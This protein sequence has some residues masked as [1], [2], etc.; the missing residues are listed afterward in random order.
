[1]FSQYIDYRDFLITT[2]EA[3]PFSDTTNIDIFLVILKAPVIL[4]ELKNSKILIFPF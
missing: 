4:H 3:L 2:I 1:M